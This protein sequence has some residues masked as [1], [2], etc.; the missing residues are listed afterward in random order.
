MWHPINFRPVTHNDFTQP[1]CWQRLSV[2]KTNVKKIIRVG[3][4]HRNRDAYQLMTAFILA[5][6]ALRRFTK[7]LPTPPLWKM[8]SLQELRPVVGAS[9]SKWLQMIKKYVKCR[10]SSCD[11]HS[12]GGGCHFAHDAKKAIQ[13]R[14]AP[15]VIYK[16]VV[17]GHWKAADVTI[18]AIV[19][20]CEAFRLSKA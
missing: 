12:N 2:E 4:G 9:P 17:R 7:V 11:V 13:R 6:S 10:N 18:H 15:S 5:M 3:D 8:I 16:N 1:S 14:D 19:I 20:S